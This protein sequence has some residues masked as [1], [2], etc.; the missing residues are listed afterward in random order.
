MR[1]KQ[2]VSRSACSQS[3][4]ISLYRDMNLSGKGKN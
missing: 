3:K 2:L 4:S 1:E